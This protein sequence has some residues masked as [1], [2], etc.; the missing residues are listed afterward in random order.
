[1]DS[2]ANS[3]LSPRNE[4]TRLCVRILNAYK[5]PPLY[6]NKEKSVTRYVM[7]ITDSSTH[8]SWQMVHRYSDFV[9]L[10]QQLSD[11]LRVHK[12]KK[13]DLP[14]LNSSVYTLRPI[15][16]GST[17]AYD[18]RLI[19]E[20]IHSLQAFINSLIGLFGEDNAILNTFLG[21]DQSGVLLDSLQLDNQEQPTSPSSP[22]SPP[23]RSSFY[24]KEFYRQSVNSN[25]LSD[26]LFLSDDSGSDNEDDI[27]SNGNGYGTETE[28]KSRQQ[29]RAVLA[30]LKHASQ[31]ISWRFSSAASASK[32][33][34][35]TSSANPTTI[36]KSSISSSS[37]PA[38]ASTGGDYGIGGIDIKEVLSLRSA[39]RR[40][41][42]DK[43]DG[44]DSGSNVNKIETFRLL[45]TVVPNF[46]NGL[47]ATIIS[48]SCHIVT[49]TFCLILA[50]TG[51]SSAIA[52]QRAA[53][54]YGVSMGVTF[55]GLLSV[56]NSRGLLILYSLFWA[57]VL[58]LL[59]ASL[60]FYSVL[61]TELASVLQLGSTIT[62]EEVARGAMA[63][64]E[65]N[66]TI[67]NIFKATATVGQS[68]LLAIK[69]QL[70][71][72]A[73]V[74]MSITDHSPI[75]MLLT[76]F[77]VIIVIAYSR[78]KRAQRAVYIYCLGCGLITFYASVQIICNLL[79]LSKSSRTV[80]FESLD[81]F[82]APFITFEL[83]RLRSIFVKFAQYFGARSDVVSSVWTKSLSKLQDAC[84]F[85]SS[86][87]VK[88]TIEAEFNRPME[89]IFTSFDMH[90]IAS[91][92]IAQVHT[93]TVN[94]LAFERPT[95]QHVEAEETDPSFDMHAGSTRA[96]SSSS[97]TSIAV[98]VK[99]QHE[100]VKEIMTSDMTISIKLAK[101]ATRLDSR[102]EVS[103]SV[104]VLCRPI[105]VCIA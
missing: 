7:K 38:P 37:I 47:V 50:L 95:D 29:N 63:F 24:S 30:V 10:R 78:D 48:V 1:M 15:I 19:D 80:V 72:V 46:S 73:L 70:F 81:Y 87:Y 66:L 71:F 8:S 58:S 42:E 68:F 27:N 52:G 3:V 93:A 64:I 92:S 67:G 60:N 77:T 43:V 55:V 65:S 105:A 101:F 2:S 75:I 40:I 9:R 44:S 100:N 102:W 32:P 74:F 61:L 53:S 57:A 18:Q 45:S 94:V 90:P 28:R 14:K 33:S 31:P 59:T 6:L 86:E 39:V 103:Q 20:R 11:F 62:H 21:N 35:A 26:T 89:E 96:S 98:V 85:S 88:T 34:H 54:L 36:V 12:K 83:G 49:S 69:A 56:S 84:P 91:A 82:I 41:E 51:C 99:V 97:S 25:R 23:P 79:R 4:I 16:I 104:C 22:M 13:F 17:A 5:D 76:I